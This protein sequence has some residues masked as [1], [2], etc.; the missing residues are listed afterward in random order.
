VME[1]LPGGTVWDLF[2]SEG[3][4]AP[5]ACATV[6][7]TCAGL[8]LAHDRGVLH[9][10]IKPEN[11]MFAGD[12]T[13]KVTDFGI[14]EV[15][16]G[17]ETVTTVGGAVIGT[18]AYM[19]PEQALGLALAPTADVYATGTVLYELLSGTLP[20]SL[21][22]EP[23]EVLERRAHEEPVPLSDAAPQAP[24]P[25]V[26][27]AMRALR[28]EPGDRYESAE[29]FGVA[30]GNAAGKAF[31]AG[32]LGRANVTL[33]ATGT[34]AAAA[35]PALDVPGDG[36]DDVT[37]SIAGRAA[38]GTVVSGGGQVDETPVQ[39]RATAARGPGI[40]LA[41]LRPEDLVRVDDLI[42]PP[43]RPWVSLVATP[44]LLGAM[45]VLGAIGIAGPSRSGPLP[46]G[47]VTVD[48]VDLGTSDSV[49]A[50]LADPIPVMVAELPT[51]AEG[52]QYAQF[53]FSAVGVGLGSSRSAPL[54]PGADGG[55]TAD[56]DA[57]RIRILASGDLTAEFRLLDEEKE[58]L[59]R[60]DFAL[61][62][63]APFI[64]TATGVA[65]LLLVLFVVSY[66][67]SVTQPLRRGYSRR[68][69]YVG[70]SILG[71][72]AGVAT[73]LLAWSL[74][75]GEPTVVTFLV[76]A[77]LGAAGF[78]FLT[79]VTIVAGR[80]RRLRRAEQRALAENVT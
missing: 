9:R 50:D 72:V 54:E 55:L 5:T 77:A 12:R 66:G 25:L 10:D 17:D 27:V 36:H 19:A 75:A 70:L 64:L 29:A 21:E 61:D 57:E 18:P 63:E 15:F 22:G 38:G 60:H 80:R 56:V 53:G 47:L 28:R 48:G 59:L 51:E 43:R 26:D 7:A 52:A 13:L 8:Q 40:A 67:M 34:I 79:R 73:T 3:L 68:S 1:A 20:F 37:T 41:D 46:S 76:S 49:G 35:G 58:I 32:W 31:G 33:A 69:A 14:A 30:L 11:L 2:T 44:L 45:V 6:L 16:G 24:S 65:G 74:G 78:A 62:P 23:L 42:S 39:V 71:G 4:T